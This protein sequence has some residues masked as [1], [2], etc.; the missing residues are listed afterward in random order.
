MK[1]KSMVNRKEIKVKARGGNKR[2][3]R[4]KESFWISNLNCKILKNYSPH[5]C[6]E[7]TLMDRALRNLV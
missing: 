1:M 5:L 6:H 7:S 4:R 3:R 2:Q